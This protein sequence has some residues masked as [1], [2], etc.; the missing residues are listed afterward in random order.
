MSRRESL[1]CNQCSKFFTEAEA[2]SEKTFS[3]S[4]LEPPEY[5]HK[6]PDCGAYNDG[7]HEW[8]SVR[9]QIVCDCC[10]EVIVKHDG[11]VCIECATQEEEA[12]YDALQGH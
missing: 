11:E 9:D 5:E 3:G 1:F 4:R 2:E 7:W 10:E 6:C 8:I 12:R